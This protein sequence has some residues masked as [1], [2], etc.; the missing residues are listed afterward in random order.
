M[1]KEDLERIAREVKERE[2]KA[3]CTAEEELIQRTLQE[4]EAARAMESPPRDENNEVLDYY[5]ALDQDS[6]MASS[7]QGTV[8]MSSQDT[9]PTSSQETAPILAWKA[10]PMP[11]HP[12]RSQLLVWRLLRVP[13]YSMLQM[14]PIWRT[15][16]V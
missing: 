7:S 16:P 13:L 11:L 15:S 3:R 8:P 9:A 10:R 4:K 6:E 2:E 14:G 12:V 5:D 1:D